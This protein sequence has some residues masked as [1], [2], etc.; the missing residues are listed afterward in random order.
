V[1]AWSAAVQR[2]VSGIG[3]SRI[4]TWIGLFS[5]GRILGC[6]QPEAKGFVSFTAVTPASGTG[7]NRN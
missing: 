1:A 2:I 6:K 5:Y 3:L 7:P 4:R